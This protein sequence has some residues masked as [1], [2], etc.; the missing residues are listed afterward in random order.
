MTMHQILRQ[1]QGSFEYPDTGFESQGRVKCFD[2]AHA[3]QEPQNR[4][5]H[6]HLNI[7]RSS[8]FADLYRRQIGCFG[9]REKTTKKTTNCITRSSNPPHTIIR[10]FRLPDLA[11]QNFYTY[12]LWMLYIYVCIIQICYTYLHVLLRYVI[13]ICIYYLDML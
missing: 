11:A 12:L 7:F 13:H 4:S 5:S 6:S 9:I 8:P 10:C 2:S 1:N 3:R